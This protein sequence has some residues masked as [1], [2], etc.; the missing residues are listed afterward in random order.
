MSVPLCNSLHRRV[1]RVYKIRSNLF[2][3][4]ASYVLHLCVPSR[5]SHGLVFLRA[6]ARIML[7]G[8]AYMA[9]ATHTYPDMDT[10]H[11][12]PPDA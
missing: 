1:Y 11:P 3:T 9:S 5:A 7:F 12:L 4:P 10:D 8:F 6:L 2:A